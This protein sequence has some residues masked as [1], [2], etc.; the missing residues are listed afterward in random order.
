MGVAKE[1]LIEQPPKSLGL[2]VG[3]VIRTKGERGWRRIIEVKANGDMVAQ[4]CDA[5]GLTRREVKKN[6]AIGR[7]IAK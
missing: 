6:A 1:R 5:P 4:V 3:A 2:H 7:T